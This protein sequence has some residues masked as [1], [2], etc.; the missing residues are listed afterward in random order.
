MQERFV[1]LREYT[2]LS[3]DRVISGI[4][5]T[6]A[7]QALP[8]K[9]SNLP[10]MFSASSVQNPIVMTTSKAKQR[11]QRNNVVRGSTFVYKFRLA[12]MK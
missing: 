1:K 12:K 5:W 4:I 3:S 6:R 8:P 11:C 10:S 9:F 7:H 2:R